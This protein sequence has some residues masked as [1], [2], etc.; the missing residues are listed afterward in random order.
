MGTK[1]VRGGKAI[2]TGT[3]VDM[4]LLKE[5]TDDE[6][7]KFQ[8]WEKVPES[9]I[10]RNIQ[11]KKKRKLEWMKIK[12]LW[13]NMAVKKNIWRFLIVANCLPPKDPDMDELKCM[14]RL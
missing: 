12:S 7:E 11:Y 8:K 6:I 1:K 3:E 5:E 10:S 4:Q 13:S 14:L 9:H 2:E